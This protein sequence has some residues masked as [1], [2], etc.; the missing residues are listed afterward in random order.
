MAWDFVFVA[1]DHS[2]CPW[3]GN[4]GRQFQPPQRYKLANTLKNEQ[5]SSNWLMDITC[6]LLIPLIPARAAWTMHY[7]EQTNLSVII[8]SSPDPQMEGL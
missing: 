4:N 7:V 5:Y 8:L 1:S 2:M 6:S 3:S